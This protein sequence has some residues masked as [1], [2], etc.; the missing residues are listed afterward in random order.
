MSST[1]KINEPFPFM[2]LPFE[3]RI[4]VLIK[5]DLREIGRIGQVSK[6]LMRE[7]RDDQVWRFNA[8]YLHLSSKG[9]SIFVGVKNAILYLRKRSTDLNWQKSLFWTFQGLKQLASQYCVYA[10]R[11]HLA[12]RPRIFG[13][14]NQPINPLQYRTTLEFLKEA[15]KFNNWCLTNRDR[16]ITASLDEDLIEED[17][18]DFDLRNKELL[19]VPFALTFLH[20]LKFLNLSHNKIDA[21]PS[22]ACNW[23]ALN[24]LDLA[25]NC[26]TSCPEEI[27][28]LTQL[29][30][31]DISHNRILSIPEW[32]RNFAQILSFNYAGN[33]ITALPA[34]M[35]KLFMSEG[36]EH[37]ESDANDSLLLQLASQVNCP[38][39]AWGSE[40]Q[41][42]ETSYQ[43][44]EFFYV[45]DEL[46]DNIKPL[47][48]DIL[49]RK[50]CF[51][52]EDINYIQKW[53]S[54]RDS[55]ILWNT[56]AK[57]IG[58][59]ASPGIENFTHSSEYFA[60]AS[61]FPEWCERNKKALS[62][63]TTLNLSH[64]DLSELPKE[65]AYL[66]NLVELDLS[67]NA[68]RSLP[69]EFA[70][71]TRLLRLN[72]DQNLFVFAPI[73]LQSMV[74][75]QELRICRSGRFFIKYKW[76]DILYNLKELRVLTHDYE[77]GP[78]DINDF[79]PNLIA[80]NQDNNG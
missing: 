48:L 17:A 11:G 2:D 8:N 18:L 65:I 44:G 26:L 69:Q 57:Q 46:I 50:I 19:I 28:D 9:E 71:L 64:Q 13:L 76:S 38:I 22:E 43:I 59:C 7:S 62:A 25:H 15:R 30:V 51:T 32:V 29:S 10:H 33:P 21:L 39:L 42:S 20:G 55:L 75:L 53:I 73:E 72:L 27:R 78:E 35:I 61:E 63:L 80:L 77:D 60:K 36:F 79:F 54:A 49:K 24:D 70:T 74:Q 52:I 41:L 68:L 23:H 16:L 31:L 6:Q 45:F 34:A 5:L 40:E 1:S 66:T 67:H 14:L 37:D 3:K 58:N 12:V 56:L 4:E 47:P